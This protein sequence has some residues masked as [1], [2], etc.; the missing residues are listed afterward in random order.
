MFEHQEG[1]ETS[2]GY[3]E[4]CGCEMQESEDEKPECSNPFCLSRAEQ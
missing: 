1:T 3:C 4:W 2:M